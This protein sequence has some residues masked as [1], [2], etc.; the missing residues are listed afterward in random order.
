MKF[1]FLI[2]FGQVIYVYT[3]IYMYNTCMYCAW[4]KKLGAKA[5]LL[6][7]ELSIRAVCADWFVVYM[8]YIREGVLKL[9]RFS[10]NRKK[11]GNKIC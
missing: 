9:Q 11:C 2:E 7:K 1:N 5:T 6:K 4:W 8:M 3:F 10:E